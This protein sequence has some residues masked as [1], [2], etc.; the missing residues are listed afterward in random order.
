MNQVNWHRFGRTEPARFTLSSPSS[1]SLPL[2]LPWPTRSPFR[3]R[4]RRPIPACSGH[5]RRRAR[6]QKKALST[7]SLLLPVDLLFL[8]RCVRAQPIPRV[9]VSVMASLRRASPSPSSLAMAW[10]RTLPSVSTP[11]FPSFSTDA[12]V[13]D[14]SP[15]E[16]SVAARLLVLPT[17]ALFRRRCGAHLRATVV[18]GWCCCGAGVAVV[19]L[20]PL[21]LRHDHTGTAPSS[22]RYG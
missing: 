19:R 6:A 15:V 7:L 13:L 21:V 12:C 10:Q 20:P 2:S 14:R 16:V 17:P 4:R 22:C 18:L 5:L 1:L 9:R 8:L 11:R 3:L